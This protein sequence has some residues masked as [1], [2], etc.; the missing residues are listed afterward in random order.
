M[1]HFQA[2]PRVSSSDAYRALGADAARGD[3]RR[4]P[5]TRYLAAEA[6]RLEELKQALW[7]AFVA[8][9]AHGIPMPLVEL[10]ATYANIVRLQINLRSTA[11]TPRRQ[12]QRSPAGSG[13]RSTT[14]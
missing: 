5:D 9:P 8:A 6:E 2:S 12:Q 7:A 4:A 14:P 11:A 10:T 13:A 3:E 1:S